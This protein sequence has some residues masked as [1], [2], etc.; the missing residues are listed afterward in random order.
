MEHYRRDTIE[1]ELLRKGAWNSFYR[2]D[3]PGGP[4]E[5]I[6]RNNGQFLAAKMLLLGFKPGENSNCVMKPGKSDEPDL[7][8]T[9]ARIGARLFVARLLAVDRP[10][11]YFEGLPV[12]TNW[13]IEL[14]GGVG[15]VSE[16]DMDSAVRE[17]MEETGLASADDIICT[18][19]LVARYAN[20]AG[21][22][23]EL[24]STQ[25]CL[26][27]NIPKDPPLRE[28]ISSKYSKIVPLNDAIPFL[29]EQSRKGVMVEGH[30]LMAFYALF[31][32]LAQLGVDLRT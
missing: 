18:E 27:R 17:M 5:V 4:R 3:T 9:I 11:T 2:V 31:Y 7:F 19:P 23:P 29:L 14:P 6:A 26:A 8:R 1:P 22:Q 24:Y 16:S 15:E 32:R 10:I 20:D 21:A 28:G 30:A 12:T 13:Q 25:V